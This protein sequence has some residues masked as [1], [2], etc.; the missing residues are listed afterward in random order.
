MPNRMQFPDVLLTASPLHPATIG[1]D[2]DVDADLDIDNGY[3]DAAG[4]AAQTL[5]DWQ[6]LASVIDHTLLKP[7][8]TRTQVE[9][10]CDEAI[11]YRFA[12]AMV[13]PVWVSTAASLLAGTHR[14]GHRLSARSI[15]GLH[16]AP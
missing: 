6:S 14:R 2:T 16:P 13:N 4:F 5:S 15:A 8:A 10:L 1:L 3:F 9:N 7:D 12:C 11:R